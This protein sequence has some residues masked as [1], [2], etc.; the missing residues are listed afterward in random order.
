MDIPESLF[1]EITVE[2]F[3]RDYWQK[4][5]LLVRSAWPQFLSPLEPED[6][7][8]LAQRDDAD[9]RLILREGGDYKWEARFGP[10][11]ED[12]ITGLRESDWTLL[13]QEVDRMI[14]EVSAL[15]QSVPFLH[16]WRIDDIMVSYATDGGG[17]G[18]HIDNYDVF[19]IQGIGKRKWEIE[20]EPVEDEELLPDLDV[21]ILSHFE[22]TDTWILEPGDMLYLPP[23]IAH[24]GTAVGDC[25]TYSIGCLAPSK[26]DL[27]SAFVENLFEAGIDETPFSGRE[28]S[29]EFDSGLISTELK[30]F[31]RK[32]VSESM[33]ETEG[34]N[35][36][37][38]RYLSRSSRGWLPPVPESVI[39]S[40][41]LRERLE[42][43]A[44]VR[45]SVV[46]MVMYDQLPD[47]SLML[48]AGGEEYAV[49]AKYA[50]ILARLT[51]RQGLAL[52]RL[53]Q[54][55]AFTNVIVDLINQGFFEIHSSG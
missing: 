34:F 28:K 9:S 41:E 55:E 52:E 37:L 4:R 2:E 20:G 46:S 33:Q 7:I 45:A 51:G 25:L 47:G 11:D 29:G 1:G 36:W 23:R 14:P 18:A 22:P 43:G 13:I 40:E 35:R 32:A 53:P 54:D 8:Q 19:L 30:E 50:S 15:L 49:D 44:H 3:L 31:A 12:E 17:V 38:G 5:S 10:F 26:N 16:N 42:E 21:R 24:R 48:F 6:L 39:T 27:V